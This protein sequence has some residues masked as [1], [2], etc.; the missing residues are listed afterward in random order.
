M[1]RFASRLRGL[2]PAVSRRAFWAAV[3][4]AAVLRCGI[5]QFQLAYTWV[6][7]APLDDEL[8]FRAANAVSAGQ[9]LGQYDYL[10]LSKRMFFAVWLALLHLLHLPYLLG[11]ALLWC[12]SSLL[13]AFALRPLWRGAGAGRAR[14]LCLTLYILLAFLP[15][16]W[17]S[18]TL[19]VYR[20]NIFPA[21]CLLC[22]A[23]MSG[24]LLRAMR[25]QGAR[26]PFLLAAGIGLAGG[27]LDRE[28]AA[29][30][31]LPF[32]AAVSLVLLAAELRRRNWP[33]AAAQVIPYAVLGVGVGVFCA[34]N[35]ACY[36]VWGLSDFS[37]G[38]FADAMGAMTRVATDSED[39]LLSIPADARARL[40]EAVPELQCLQYWLEED[41][42]L[43]NDFR[44]PE[45]G[46]Y[47]AGSLY[48]AIR[49]AAQYEGIYADAATAAA[50]WRGVADAVNAA[51]DD[52]TLPTRGGARSGTSQPVRARY[53][54]PTIA[55]AA[56][57]AV[58]VLTFQDC[59]AYYKSLR[60]IG[61]Q[62]DIARWS[63][64]LH[65]AFNDAAEAGKDTPYY[66]P[67]QRL[68]YRALD[69]LRLVYAAGLTVG[70]AAAVL[71]HLRAARAALGGR[72]EPAAIWLMLLALLAMAA[73]RCGMIAFVEV[74]SFGIGTST[75][76]L[77]AVHPLLVLYAFGC[78]AVYRKGAVHD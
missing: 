68:V 23:G 65:C 28:D 36:G 16:S 1:Q 78:A 25:R 8:M 33:G 57:S 48:W 58:W 22:L 19:R 20:D 71:W 9:W 34:L 4:A 17:A 77:A 44:D 51:C 3:L 64:Y 66:A 6:G 72:G 15:S 59:P 29:F 40:Y 13:A 76:Y 61:T 70:F 11:G 50:Y 10:T 37:E 56:R 32:S 41:A 45:R 62:D 42:Q 75:M 21:L 26:W 46:D 30:F 38:A 49:R 5:T 52:G 35:A 73:L 69:A 39:P 63:A 12:A 31:L 7:G 54:L 14:T 74:S 47:R 27:V 18:Y 55:E 53:V 60:S 67:I 43:Q 2:C 24:A